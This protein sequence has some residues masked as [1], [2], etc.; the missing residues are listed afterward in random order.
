MAIEVVIPLLRIFLSNPSRIADGSPVIRYVFIYHA[1]CT[2]KA[3]ISD[4]SFG[5]DRRVDAYKGIRA[6]GGKS[7]QSCTGCHGG[8]TTHP[9]VVTDGRIG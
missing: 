8:I 3:E 1:A 6:N 7:G 5:K 9:G 4:M 2:D